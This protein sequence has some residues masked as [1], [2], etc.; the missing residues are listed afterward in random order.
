MTVTAFLS[1]MRA[2]RNGEN[3]AEICSK[4]FDD[5]KRIL[6]LVDKKI[7]GTKDFPTKG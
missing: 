7:W 3:P 5:G 1:E 4:D 2:L 6:M